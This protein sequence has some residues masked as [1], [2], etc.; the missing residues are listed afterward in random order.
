MKL[1]VFGAGVFGGSQEYLKKL[2]MFRA[3]C[4]KFWVDCKFYGTEQTQFPGYR[5]MKVELMIEF[6]EQDHGDVTHVMYTDT[7]DAL[8]TGPF[9]EICSK[10]DAL[11]RPPILI[12]AYTQL[13]NVSDPKRYSGCW[14]LSKPYCYPCVG[15]YIAELPLIIETL[16][17]MRD[18]LPEYGD[19]CFLWYDAWYQGWF[20][21]MLDSQC[22]IF[23][24]RSEESTD[25]VR[26]KGVP[27]I[28]NMVTDSYP[29]VLHFSGGYTD[30]VTGKDEQIIP[31]AKKLEIIPS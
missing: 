30:Q 22:Q 29:C 4:E 13:G 23:Q 24:V 3:S 31:W 12:S 28:W 19:D 20:R 11:G 25:V 17:R 8:I 6:L 27:R 1:M 16:K 15:G 26:F 9:S 2:W 5:R 18:T 21:P 7:W 10:Y 14:D